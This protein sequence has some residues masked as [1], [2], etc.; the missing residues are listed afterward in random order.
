LPIAGILVGTPNGAQAV[1]DE[2]DFFGRANLPPEITGLPMI[3]W[4]SQRGRAM[5]DVRVQVS[6]LP[7]RRMSPEQTTSVS[8]HP[9][10][11]VIAGDQ[12]PPAELVAVRAWVEANRRAIIEYWDGGLF[13]DELLQRLTRA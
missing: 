7:G 13:T 5:H 4:V 1:D 11:E 2:E 3:V 8:V 9:D 12:L 10:V 6:L